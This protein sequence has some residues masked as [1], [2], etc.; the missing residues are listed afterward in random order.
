MTGLSGTSRVMSGRM[1]IIPS[2]LGGTKFLKTAII[3][4]AEIRWEM[5][6]DR[7]GHKLVPKQRIQYT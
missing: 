1:L 3:P 4:S 2:S 6:R 7:M 5:S